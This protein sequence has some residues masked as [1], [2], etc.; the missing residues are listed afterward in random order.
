ML[1]KGIKVVDVSRLLP[2][3]FCSMILADLGAEVI[4]VESLGVGDMVRLMPPFVDGES[5]MFL[6]INHGK[7]SL[8]VNLRKEEGKQVVLRLAAT[9]DV[10][11]EGFRPGQADRNG[12]GYTHLSNVNP[13]IVYCSLSGYGQDGPFR[14]RAGHD[15]NYAALAGLL[16]TMG[17]AGARLRLPGVQFA[18]LAGG[19][20]AAIGI[21]GTLVRR[22]KSGAGAYVDASMFQSA[23]F[24]NTFAACTDLAEGVQPSALPGFLTGDFP[25]YN[26]YLT[27]DKRQVTLGALEPEFWAN[28]CGA[29]GR[30]DLLGKQFAQGPEGSATIAAVESI[31]AE[32]TWEEWAAVFAGKDVCCE[33]VNTVGEALRHPQVVERGLARAVQHPDAGMLKHICLPLNVSPQEPSA[34]PLPPPGLGQHTTEI[35]CSL[36]YS[37]DE[38]ADLRARRVVATRE[39]SPKSTRTLF[40]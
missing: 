18:D 40:G 8:A 9:A 20:F 17:F 23:L 25:C 33:P 31:F 19:M 14:D 28:F 10:F 3:P 34:A 38:I 39:D 36:G 4:K 27:K 22:E 12:I 29:I 1:L 15:N 6:S 37:D 30:D 11:L 5:A 26:L 2:G 13:R 7:K 24:L 16:D 21:L 32:R 35:L